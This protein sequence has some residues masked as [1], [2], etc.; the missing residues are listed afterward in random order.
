MATQCLANLRTDG[1]DRVQG[2]PG[3]L[4]DHRQTIAAQAS[5]LRKQHLAA[6]QG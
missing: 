2:M 4:E 6:L 3:V 1:H 5:K